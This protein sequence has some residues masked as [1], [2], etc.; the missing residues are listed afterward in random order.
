MQI[1]L[2]KAPNTQ[3][4]LE[5]GSSELT[6]LRYNVRIELWKLLPFS[7]ELCPKIIREKDFARNIRRA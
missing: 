7:A 6:F 2:M 1:M 5:A 3:I 4:Q